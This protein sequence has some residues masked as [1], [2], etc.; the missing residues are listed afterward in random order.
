MDWL[1]DIQSNRRRQVEN[2]YKSFGASTFDTLEKAVVDNDDVEEERD[3]EASSEVKN[4][5]LK[6]GEKSDM[7]KMRLLGLRKFNGQDQKE[8]IGIEDT[9][10]SYI[11]NHENGDIVIAKT[12]DGYLV[13]KFPID[14]ENNDGEEEEASTLSEAIDVAL[15][16]KEDLDAVEDPEE[17]M[18]NKTNKAQDED[19]NEEEVNPFELAAW[20]AEQEE[21]AKA[22]EALGLDEFEK[23]KHQDGD[24]HPNG[25]WVWRA[26]ANG[27]KGDWRVA[28]PGG[29]KATSGGGAKKTAAPATNADDTTTQKKITKKTLDDL[30]ETESAEI[31][32]RLKK[33]NPKITNPYTGRVMQQPRR[34]YKMLTDELRE[35][36]NGNMDLMA[37]NYGRTKEQ[38]QKVFEARKEM[39]DKGIYYDNKLKSWT[40]N[41]KPIDDK[42]IEE[43]GFK[44]D[45]NGVNWIKS[46][47]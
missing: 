17:A 16:Y 24:M 40:R 31:D 32:K 37:D 4:N 44:K 9:D 15:R 38:F 47:N 23:A 27:G 34:T 28:K 20:E 14:L 10:N 21:V 30:D 42:K 41:G 43:F 7:Y 26:S 45:H 12:Q 13:S 3:E 5:N 1:E 2:L 35:V 46:N 29:S 33:F 11:A 8:Y 19:D 39:N 22:Y 25:K 6:K 36:W 18:Y